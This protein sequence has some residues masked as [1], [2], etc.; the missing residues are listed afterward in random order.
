MP[1]ILALDT[2]GEACSVA[3]YG[4]GLCREEFALAPRE[5]TRKILP[6]VDSILASNNLT[7]ADIDGIAF[8]R[9]PG[10]FTGL[11]ITAGVV[12]GLAFG[13]NLPVVPISSLAALAYGWVQQQQSAIDTPVCV[14]FDA[15]MGEVY[16]GAYQVST[17]DCQLLGQEVVSAPHS[18]SVNF[19]STQIIALG[20]GW[21]LEGLLADKHCLHTDADSQVHALA[22]AQLAQTQFMQ[23]NVVSAEQA[24][25]VYLRNEVSWK[26]LADQ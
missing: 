16:F 22:I 6:M 24:L 15:R 11:R 21:N 2:S 5:H 26:K 17:D 7:L 12:Q 3:I 20:S 18:V 13:A 10:S 8:G 9:G 23:G 14:A 1:K 19:A 4:D 25:P